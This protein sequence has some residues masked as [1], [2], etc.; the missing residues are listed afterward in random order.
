LIVKFAGALATIVSLL[1]ST[2]AVKVVV[3]KGGLP[4]VKLDID[5]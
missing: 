5:S 1:P 4:K 3:V 2:G